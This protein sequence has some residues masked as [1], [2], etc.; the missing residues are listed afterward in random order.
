MSEGNAFSRAE[1]RFSEKK[2]FGSSTEEKA[3][4]KNLGKQR[5][6]EKLNP[7]IENYLK[8]VA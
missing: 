6:N 4:V 2:R 7:N 1:D 3:M 8:T 5:W